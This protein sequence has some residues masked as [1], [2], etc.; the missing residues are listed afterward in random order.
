MAAASPIVSGSIAGG[1][2]AVGWP[3]VAD[4]TAYIISAGTTPGGTQFLGPTNIGNQ[5][6][7]GASGLPAGFQA[8]IRVVAVN[9]CGQQGPPTDFLLR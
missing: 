9:A 4:A 3:A 6:S 1:V 8:F 7:I 5:T 2:A